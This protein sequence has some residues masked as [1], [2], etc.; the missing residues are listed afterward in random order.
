[1]YGGILIYLL[2]KVNQVGVILVIFV[3][4]LIYILYLIIQLICSGSGVV[5]NSWWDKFVGM[6][7]FDLSNLV[8]IGIYFGFIIFFIYFYVL[9]I[10]NFD[11]CVDEMKKFGGF[12]LGIWLG[13]LIVDYLCYVLSWIIL[14]GLI[15]FGVIV[16]LFNLFFQIGVG[17]I[18]QNLF[19]GGIVVLIMIG[20]GLD[21]VKQIE[22]QF[23]QCNYEGFFK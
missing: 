5:G 17:G 13:C 9:I 16:V 4:L 7:L 20:V 3:L 19:F 12:I 15:Y 2:F 10:F 6:Y 22:S 18:V 14:L 8:Y 1:M 23:M 21:M 11:E